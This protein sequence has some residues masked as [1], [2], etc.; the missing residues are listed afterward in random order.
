MPHYLN[1]LIGGPGDGTEIPAS[2]AYESCVIGI[3]PGTGQYE[4]AANPD[5][6]REPVCG[7]P[8]GDS[9]MPPVLRVKLY[10]VGRAKQ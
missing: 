2:M 10:Y 7:T 6:P 9:F 5:E 8:N 1:I 3:T 4:Y